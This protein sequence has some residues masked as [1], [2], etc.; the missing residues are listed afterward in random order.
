MGW[1]VLTSGVWEPGE[2]LTP[3]QKIWRDKILKPRK[4]GASARFC[5]RSDVKSAARISH[6]RAVIGARVEALTCSM[7]CS[8]VMDMLAFMR[9]MPLCVGLSPLREDMTLRS[10]CVV[11]R[12]P[13]ALKNWLRSSRLAC[14]CVGYLTD[15]GHGVARST[16]AATIFPRSRLLGSVASFLL[17][18][19]SATRCPVLTSGVSLP[20]PLPSTDASRLERQGAIVIRC[21]T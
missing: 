21:S 11:P 18:F 9:D 1:P 3:G 4:P 12:C 7:R 16:R 6:G 8:G 10:W 13:E 2:N 14:A 19:A 20:R 5:A 17:S 15:R